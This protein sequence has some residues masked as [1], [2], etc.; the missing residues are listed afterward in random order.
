M[1][2]QSEPYTVQELCQR[3][4]EQ[5]S[6]PL[7]S[8]VTKAAMRSIVT[9][10]EGKTKVKAMKALKAFRNRHDPHSAEASM[11]RLSLIELT[12]PK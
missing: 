5:Q 3:W 1:F 7:H 2:F 6:N 8:G 10:L 9:L 11:A 12:Y 4:T